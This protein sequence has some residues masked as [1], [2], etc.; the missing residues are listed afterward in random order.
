[1][2]G[3]SNLTGRLGFGTTDVDPR[4]LHLKEAARACCCAG[5]GFC[6]RC[7]MLLLQA[8]RVDRANVCTD[9]AR[10]LESCEDVS[11]SLRKLPFG[12]LVV[13]VV[14]DLRRRGCNAMYACVDNRFASSCFCSLESS[15]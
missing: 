9:S 14:N 7:G 4:H 13:A 6:S 10:N 5:A 11:R 2:P 8:G 3:K 12:Q 1:M 15:H